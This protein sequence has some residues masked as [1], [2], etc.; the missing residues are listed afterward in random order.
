MIILFIYFKYILL[1]MLLQ[2]SHFPPFIPLLPAYL[3]PHSFPP[4]SSCPWVIHISSLATPFPILFLISP[5]LFFTYR[6]VL[7]NSCTF[8]SML[9][10][11]H[12]SCN[13]QNDLH[14]YDSLPVLVVCL[15]C[16][17]DSVVDSCTF[18]AISMFI[19]LIFFLI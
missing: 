4:F 15:V 17:L 9:Y 2:L 6:F 10:L 5:C 7:L 1:I 18:V 19:V 14:V 13:P 16:Y 8:P 3:L 11:P 12:P